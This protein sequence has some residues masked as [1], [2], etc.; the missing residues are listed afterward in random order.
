[1]ALAGLSR[2]GLQHLV[3]TADGSCPNF[4]APLNVMSIL[5]AEA[6][7]SL[8][9]LGLVRLRAAVSGLLA[10]VSPAALGLVHAGDPDDRVGREVGR[11][12]RTPQ[13]LFPVDDVRAASVHGRESAEAF[14]AIALA[15][16]DPRA[17]AA[18][19]RVG[20][21]WTLP[22]RQEARVRGGDDAFMAA[23]ER[24]IARLSGTPLSVAPPGVAP[25]RGPRALANERSFNAAPCRRPA[26]PAGLPRG[27]GRP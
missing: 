13:A 9:A 18:L 14:R 20:A 19:A 12:L 1:M 26:D 22:V 23:V 11:A 25:A 3:R 17:A 24:S 10:G 21:T 5:L 27:S 4:A 2:L 16:S 7:P 6:S 15:R 8:R